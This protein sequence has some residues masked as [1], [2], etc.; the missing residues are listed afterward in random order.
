MQIFNDTLVSILTFKQD[1]VWSITLYP[2]IF[3]HTLVRGNKQ[4]LNHERIHLQQQKE[5]L[6]IGFYILYAYEYLV[7]RIIYKM[8]HTTAYFNIRFELE[9]YENQTNLKYLDTRKRYA[10][11]TYTATN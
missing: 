3:S 6:I 4:H 10:W 5:C 9:A 11:K 1:W 8:Y 2:F 7:N